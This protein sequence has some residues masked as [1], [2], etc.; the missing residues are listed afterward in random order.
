MK[1]PIVTSDPLFVD[2]LNNARKIPIFVEAGAEAFGRNGEE[3]SDYIVDSYP[4]GVSIIYTAMPLERN[5]G[6][7]PTKYVVISA[8]Y[9][10]C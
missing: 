6:V 3:F 2:L 10:P 5:N 7:L 1:F 8:E 9:E 4:Y